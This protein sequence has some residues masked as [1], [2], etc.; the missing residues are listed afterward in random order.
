MATT[1]K[2]ETE[3]QVLDAVRW[4]VSEASP[5]ELVGTGTKRAL[6]RPMQAE[7]TLDLS[8]LSGISLY[9]PEELILGAGPGTPLAEI[10][11]ALAAE[12]QMLPFEPMDF[13]PLFGHAAG[14]GTIGG[15]FSCN[16]SGP[17]RIKAGAARDHLLGFRS[18]TGRGDVVKSGGRVVKNV[19]GYDLSKLVCGAHGT[20]AALTEVTFKVLPAPE[21][22]RTVLVFGATGEVA[23]EAMSAAMNSPHEVASTAHLPAEVAARSAVGYVSGAGGAVTAVRVEG[24]GPSVE[25]RCSALRDAL[26]KFGTIEELHGHNSATFWR[27]VRDASLLAEPRD[28]HIWRLSVAPSESWR[29]AERLHAAGE[30]MHFHDWAGGLIWAAVAPTFTAETVR[31]AVGPN[32]G[33]ATLV[34]APADI[35]AA[36][37]V[38]EPQSGPLGSLSARVKASFDPE[39]VLNPGRMYPGV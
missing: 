19:T 23:I 36:A 14:L 5:L 3:A 21:K 35:R 25:H 20:L 16:L 27:E 9:E 22:T 29:V 18:V 7:N 2:P 15:V 28:R 10:E 33:H 4:A 34:R 24:V 1:F 37:Q 26:A 8:A 17:R 11:V 6:G 31:A 38:F 12:N 13:G 32:G 39:R 30:V